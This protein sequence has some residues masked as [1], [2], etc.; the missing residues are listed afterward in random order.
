MVL[1]L[2][3]APAARPASSGVVQVVI[4]KVAFAQLKAPLRVGD[5]L[6]FVNNDVV[7]H[8]ATEKTKAWDATIRV[9]RKA[10]VE[11]K[12]A[13]TIEYYCRFHPNMVGRIVVR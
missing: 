13:G 3:V 9:G 5:V 11:M 2:S 7:D 12:A 6:E 10:R 1:P 8:T 4:D